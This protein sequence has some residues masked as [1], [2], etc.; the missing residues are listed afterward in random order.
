MNAA[1]GSM[2]NAG[3][4]ALAVVVAAGAPWQARANGGGYSFG[5]Q[6]TGSV[7]PFQA[8]GTEHVKIEDEQL[9]VALRRTCAAVTVRYTMRNV[10]AA[11]VKVRFGFPVEATRADDY[12][13]DEGMKPPISEFRRKDLL[14]SIQQLRDYS[15]TADGR[16]VK[17]AFELEPFAAGRVKPFEGSEALVGIAGWMVSEVT[18]PVGAPLTLE[19]R[20]CAAYTG[21][22]T[23]ASDDSRTGS[24]WFVYRL[25]TGAVWAG[26]IAR[27]TITVR[28]DGIAPEEIAIDGG[29]LNRVGDGWVR[30][31]RNL[32]PTLADDLRIRA[33]PGAYWP[34]SFRRDGPDAYLAVMRRNEDDR[35][36]RGSW[37]GAHQRFRAAASST[38]APAKDHG[39][40]AEHLAELSPRHP[41]AEGAAG[42]GVGEWVELVPR[43][44]RPLLALEVH[45]GFQGGDPKAKLFEK[46]GRPA[47]VS[48][49]LNGEHRF[50][51]TLGDGPDAQ[52]IPIVGYTKPVSRIR[53]TILEVFPGTKYEDTCISRIVLYD[54][55]A[56]P[57]EFQGSR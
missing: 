18:Y 23:W 26:P 52:L 28:A 2:Q 27:G 19:I 54:L 31:L 34:G 4:I 11:P 53:V 56:K 1:V 43:K 41:W 29:G 36:E 47:R 51:A 35:S 3:L 13:V 21:S 12:D 8:S 48:I 15:V 22:D 10:S 9:D 6:F 44:P 40:G 17:A 49:L 55:L 33:M 57:P 39:F 38:L 50:E 24:R 20:Y 32:E 42:H 5:V 16:P 30:E 14:A 25:S 7:A 37:G 45:P 46:N